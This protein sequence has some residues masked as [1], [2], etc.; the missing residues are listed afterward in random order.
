NY[1][2]FWCG[3]DAG[4]IDELFR[5]SGLFRSKWN[6]EDYRDRTIALAM[7]GEVYDLSCG[8]HKTNGSTCSH[9]GEQATSA[10]E[11]PPWPEPMPL[12]GTPLGPPF[13]A[14]CLPSWLGGWVEEE[15]RATQTPPDLA[16]MLALAICAAALAKKFR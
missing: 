9:E 13:P 10:S 5:R 7:D 2:R 3:Q 12:D 16:A 11:P 4:R 1:L 14:E 8:K 6:R 15:A